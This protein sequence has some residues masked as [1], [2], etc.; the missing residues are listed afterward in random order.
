MEL[1]PNGEGKGVAKKLCTPDIIPLIG[2]ARTS[3]EKYVTSK[4]HFSTLV[5]ITEGDC[6]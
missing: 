1:Q 3:L 5:A 6:T 2:P 4:I